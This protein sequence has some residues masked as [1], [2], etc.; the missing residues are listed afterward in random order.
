MIETSLTLCL[1]I[2]N[3]KLVCLSIAFLTYVRQ[4][5]VHCSQMF[6][7]LR[8]LRVNFAHFLNGMRETG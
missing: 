1:S 3:N 8:I 7:W 5:L 6:V 2:Y 4:F